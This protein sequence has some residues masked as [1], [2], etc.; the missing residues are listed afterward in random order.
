M[1]LVKAAPLIALLAVFVAACGGT[2]PATQVP[3]GGPTSGPPVTGGPAAT[4]GPAGTTAGAGS[5]PAGW[6]A[7]GKARFEVTGPVTVSD[8]LGFLRAASIFGGT[9]QTYLSFTVDGTQST[10]VVVIAADTVAATYTSP[11]LTAA[12]T[13]CTSSNLKVEASSASGSIECSQVSIVQA[14]GA[15]V[16]NGHISATFDAH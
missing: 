10:F 4:S 11:Q 7:N 6:D 14:T 8:E 15:T 3:G 9:T 12:G 5:K 13:T 2:P 1:Q 16:V